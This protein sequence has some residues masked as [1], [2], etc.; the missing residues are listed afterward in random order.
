MQKTYPLTLADLPGWRGSAY[1]RGSAVSR[2]VVTLEHDCPEPRRHRRLFG[3]GESVEEA[4]AAALKW[5]ERKTTRT[6]TTASGN[7]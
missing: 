4:L 6:P 3:H 5:V 1:D 2:F 7:D